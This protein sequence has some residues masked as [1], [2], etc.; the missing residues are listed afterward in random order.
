V[1]L[2]APS[3]W[4][5]VYPALAGTVG[6]ALSMVGTLPYLRD[7][8]EGRTRPHRGTWAIWGVIGV[9]G[10]VSHAAEGGRWSLA[11]IAVQTLTTL[12]VLV[13][14]T[15]RGVGSVTAP[16]LAL[17]ALA[18]A[19]VLGWIWSSNPMTA[20]VCV[21]VADAV[22]VAMMLPKTWADPHGET[23]STFSLA[24]VSGLLGMVAGFDPALLLLPA[25]L[26]LANGVV[27]AFIA[28]RRLVG[29]GR[30]ALPRYGVGRA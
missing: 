14:A 7:I 15:R 4:T 18:M 9:V 19:G 17:L 13:L 25:Y 5:A 27:T 26:C 12:A 8:R 16:N 3:D 23:L 1:S 29:S 22:G 6:A 28:G 20:T 24:T 21:I 11:V 30:P 2:P 10:T